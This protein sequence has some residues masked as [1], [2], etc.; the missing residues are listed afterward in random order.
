MNADNPFCRRFRVSGRC[1]RVDLAE[2]SEDFRRLG[3]TE[4]VR[5]DVDESDDMITIDDDDGGLGKLG[6]ARSRQLTDP[7]LGRLT[8]GHLVAREG[9]AEAAR[10]RV[11]FI[12]RHREMQSVTAAYLVQT[13]LDKVRADRH[14]RHSFFRESGPELAVIIR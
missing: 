11:A 6:R 5:T 2:G 1:A 3:S 14:E 9:D 13:G 7:A 4:P 12:R 8:L 10:K